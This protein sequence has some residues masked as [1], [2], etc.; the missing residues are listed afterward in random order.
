MRLVYAPR[1]DQ[2]D[3]AHHQVLYLAMDEFNLQAQMQG[4]G[5]R[6][7]AEEVT[8]LEPLTPAVAKAACLDLLRGGYVKVFYRAGLAGKESDEDRYLSDEESAALL[9]DPLT[10]DRES[11]EGIQRAWVH[12]LHL[13]PE[14]HELFEQGHREFGQEL[15][16]I[17]RRA[18]AEIDRVHQEHPEF[19]EEQER[20]FQD[21]E[22]WVETGQGEM[23]KPPSWPST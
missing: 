21:M 4:M 1:V 6:I 10:W 3:A 8:V 14:G 20:Y 22:R 13:T 18:R 23:P 11:E 19:S 16:R 5:T 9:E 17:D 12:E 7:G 2:L 15:D